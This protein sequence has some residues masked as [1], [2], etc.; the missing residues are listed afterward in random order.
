MI[1]SEEIFMKAVFKNLFPKFVQ[2]VFFSV[3]HI[4]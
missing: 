4:I 3:E 1:H 2:S